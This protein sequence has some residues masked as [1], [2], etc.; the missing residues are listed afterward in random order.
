M[1][2]LS[3]TYRNTSNNNKDCLSP[4]SVNLI[5]GYNSY[6]FGADPVGGD[7]SFVGTLTCKENC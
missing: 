3:S 4:V 7:L 1:N 2:K 5:Q 6:C